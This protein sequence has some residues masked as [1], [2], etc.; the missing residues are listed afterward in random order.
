[1]NPQILQTA[2]ALTSGLVFGFGL[3]LSGMLN[4]ARVQGF[5]D[6]FGVW[7]PSLAFVLGGAVIIAFVGVRVMYRMD[8]PF[9]MD[10]SMSRRTKRSTRRSLSVRLCLALV[11]AS[12]VSAPARRL[13]PCRSASVNPWS[14]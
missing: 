14:L 1:M 12:V 5:L 9:S 3:S 2:A 4:P 6:I 11:G 8:R 13:R 10:P 7:D